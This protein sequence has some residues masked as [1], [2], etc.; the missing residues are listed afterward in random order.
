MRTPL[1][2]IKGD[3]SLALARP[4]AA[5]YYHRVLVET[6]EEV[7]QMNRLVERLLTLARSDAEGV[8]LH[9]QKIDLSVLLDNAIKYTPSPGRLRLSAHRAGHGSGEIRIAISDS[10][11]GIPAGHLSHI[12]DRFYRVDRARSRELGGACLASP[13]PAS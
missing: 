2:I 12:F 13:S 8:T 11:P 3:L 7:D 4:R 9:R 5:G 10:G 6:D 1:T